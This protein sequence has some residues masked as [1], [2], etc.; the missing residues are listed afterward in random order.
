MSKLELAESFA[1][2][3]HSKLMSFDGKPYFTHLENVV[4]RL[5]NLGMTSEEVLCS[6]WLHD[7]IEEN[8]A[9]FDDIF[10]RFG[11][12]IAIYVSSLS[13]NPSLPKKDR[14]L[15]FV[16][17]L[18]DAPFEVKLIKLCDISANIRELDM[19]SISKT[20]KL[21]HLKQRRHYLNVIKNGLL[22]NES[23]Q[24][25]IQK[26]FVGINQ[27]FTKYNIKPVFLM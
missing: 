18:Q 5:K 3:K 21:K 11:R 7:L 4:N 15:Q 9:S 8:L 24:I 27:I 14:E 19:S 22:E 25:G 6:A 10:E 1:R 13:K 16:K 17:Q 12:T 20:A 2:E 23:K 26:I